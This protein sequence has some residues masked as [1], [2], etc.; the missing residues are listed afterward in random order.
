MADQ[1]ENSLHRR[2]MAGIKIALFGGL[3]QFAVYY[4][5]SWLD[6]VQG[7]KSLHDRIIDQC[8]DVLYFLSFWTMLVSE[9]VAFV[10]LM[11]WRCFTGKIALVTV[12]AVLWGLF[13]F[14]WVYLGRVEGLP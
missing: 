5:F 14:F 9:L 11:A 2:G 8:F 13:L 1:H 10:W 6:P 7:G 3:L 12:C 4:L